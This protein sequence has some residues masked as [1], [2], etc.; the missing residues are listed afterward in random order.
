MRKQL[1]CGMGYCISQG[2]PEK[3]NQYKRRCVMGIGSHD[4]GGCEKSHHVLSAS[5]RTRKAGCII[6]EMGG[7]CGVKA[8]GVSPGEKGLRKRRSS[9]V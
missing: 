3:Q 7:K 9:N 5:C 2:S 4:Y 1:D 8:A 6:P